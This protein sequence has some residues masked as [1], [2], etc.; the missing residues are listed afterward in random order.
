MLM[1][2]DTLPLGIF[3]MFKDR[4]NNIIGIAIVIYTSETVEKRRAFKTPSAKKR[5]RHWR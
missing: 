3:R 4:L 2:Y 5:R 1:I